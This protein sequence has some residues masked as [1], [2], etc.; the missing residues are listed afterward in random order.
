MQEK[1]YAF[2]REMTSIQ[3]GFLIHSWEWERQ[4]I[5]RVTNC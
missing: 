3:R 4:R 2:L 1:E 5:L